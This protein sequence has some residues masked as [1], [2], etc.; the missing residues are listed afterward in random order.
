MPVL[1]ICL[2]S[3]GQQTKV[4]GIF[5]VPTGD[6]ST[7]Y[8]RWYSYNNS[9]SVEVNS[10]NVTGADTLYVYAT[11]SVDSGAYALIWVDQNLDGVNDNP[12]T[13]STTVNTFLWGEAWPAEW[14][15]HKIAKGGG[16]AGE[17]HYYTLT[18][19]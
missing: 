12:W 8:H 10:T 15:V 9:W 16:L 3:F 7:F 17:Q 13:L 4:S 2:A 1:L 19:R 14:I 6:D 18:K 5:T 11:S